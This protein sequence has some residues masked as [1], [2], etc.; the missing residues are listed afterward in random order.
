MYCEHTEV[1]ELH[2]NGTVNYIDG[3]NTFQPQLP[4]GRHFDQICHLWESLHTTV[5]K[6]NVTYQFGCKADL[7]S[8]TIQALI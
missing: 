8:V 4:H 7:A 3:F 2:G 5:L 1:M 6:A